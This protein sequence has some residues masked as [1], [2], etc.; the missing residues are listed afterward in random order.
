VGLEGWVGG[1]GVQWMCG[2][3]GKG[4]YLFL[5]VAWNGSIWVLGLVEC[6]KTDEG[7]VPVCRVG[8]APR[9]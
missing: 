6:L 2:V 4:C 5:G 3:L 1:S 7:G 8:S 9:F